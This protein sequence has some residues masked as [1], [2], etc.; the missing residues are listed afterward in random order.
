M[1]LPVLWLINGA[2][3]YASTEEQLTQTLKPR[4]SRPSGIVFL[5]LHF[6]Y[7]LSNSNRI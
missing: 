3:P 4:R 1:E 6:I 2:Q 7:I 5:H